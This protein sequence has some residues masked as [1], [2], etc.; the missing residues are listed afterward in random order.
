N[1]KDFDIVV[2]GETTGNDSVKDREIVEQWV[3]TGATWFQ[4]EIHGLRAEIDEL[5]ER[6]RAGPPAV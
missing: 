6:I 3:Q 5:R 4:E 1:L 2:S